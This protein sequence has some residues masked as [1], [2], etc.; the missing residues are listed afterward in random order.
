MNYRSGSTVDIDNAVEEMLCHSVSCSC[1]ES[2]EDRKRLWFGWRCGCGAEWIYQLLPFK[3]NGIGSRWREELSTAKG[4]T[5]LARLEGAAIVRNERRG[6]HIMR[7][8]M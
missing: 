8:R 5:Q 4:R 2:F 6:S 1:V 7:G 3:H